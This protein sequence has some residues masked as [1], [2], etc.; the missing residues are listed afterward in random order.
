[1]RLNN[2]NSSC[3]E[4]EK[5]QVLDVNTQYYSD[6]MKLNGSDEVATLL[7]SEDVS[8]LRRNL[9]RLDVQSLWD[10]ACDN[11]RKRTELKNEVDII[12]NDIR[13]LK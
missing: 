5:N 8:D 12:I 11:K 4:E 13:L 3:F 9:S 2:S 7:K 10:S 1:M 6:S